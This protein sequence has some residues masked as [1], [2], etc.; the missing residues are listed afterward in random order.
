MHQDAHILA[1]AHDPDDPCDLLV[2][3]AYYGEVSNPYRCDVERLDAAIE[4]VFH[5]AVAA[6]KP[7]L[8]VIAKRRDRASIAEH[9]L[10]LNVEA[11]LRRL[12][13]DVPKTL[14]ITVAGEQQE[15]T[16]EIFAPR[17]GNLPMP[18][19]R[20]P[21]SER[22][23]EFSDALQFEPAVTATIPTKRSDYTQWSL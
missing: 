18:W 9:F 13:V 15:I 16:N 14:L 1:I 12:L 23:A 20:K 5:N 4:S 17:V 7:L 6:D 21:L 8:V 10:G 22:F 2:T 19:S 3:L 11:L